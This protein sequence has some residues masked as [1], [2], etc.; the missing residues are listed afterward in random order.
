[1]N[2]NALLRPFKPA[3]SLK[4][5]FTAS[6]SLTDPITLMGVMSLL[7]RHSVRQKDAA[8]QNYDD[9]VNRSLLR[10]QSS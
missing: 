5:L 9:G 1:M 2:L 6:D 3:T 4:G 8:H 10:R 7:A